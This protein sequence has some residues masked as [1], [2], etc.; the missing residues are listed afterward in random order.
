MGAGGPTHVHFGAPFSQV[1]I[2]KKSKKIVVFRK[3]PHLTQIF[4]DNA[5]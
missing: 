4:Y 1:R 3:T 2:V 5:K